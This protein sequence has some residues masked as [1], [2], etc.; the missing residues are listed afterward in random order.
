MI[1][2]AFSTSPQ[3]FIKQVSRGNQE[4]Q[5]EVAEEGGVASCMVYVKR[6]MDKIIRDD[7]LHPELEFSWSNDKEF[8]PMVAAQ[9]NDIGLRNGSKVLNEVR[10]QNG[11][12]P[13]PP[14]IGDVP[15]IVTAT[16]AVSVEQALAP[17]PPPPTHVMAPGDAGGAGGGGLGNPPPP[18][19][20][21]PPKPAPT[22][23]PKPA[24]PPKPLKKGERPSAELD[25]PAMKAARLKAKKVIAAN[26][27][28][29]GAGVRHQVTHALLLLNKATGEPD[30]DAAATSVAAGLDLTGLDDMVDGMDDILTDIAQAAGVLTL[31]QVGLADEDKLTNQV[32]L[33]AMA[34]ARERAAELVGKRWTAEGDLI[35]NPNAE[36]AISDSTRNMVQKAIADGLRDN[37]SV[38]EIADSLVGAGEA[39]YPFSEDRAALIAETE[40]NRANSQGALAGAREAQDA[41]VDIKKVWLGGQDPCEEVCQPN[42]DQGAIEID[43]DFES[44][45]DAPPGHPGCFCSVSWEVGDAAE[46]RAPRRSRFVAMAA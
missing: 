45:D 18:A 19:A 15:M 40:V 37:L 28:K 29:V 33:S 2:F 24:D 22:P 17:P 16:G 43:E 46:K 26:L 21:D 8:D 42:I 4:S 20:G 36:W 44:G 11:D 38:P 13:Y 1:C 7:L 5:Q 6:L 41:G 30:D 12:D 32:G 25:T 27:K 31:V 34:W 9:I 39:A 10:D 35:D 3:P 23:A 14:E